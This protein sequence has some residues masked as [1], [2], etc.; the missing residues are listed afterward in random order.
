MQRTLTFEEAE[1]FKTIVNDLGFSLRKHYIAV[2][3]STMPCVGF[4]IDL[5]RHKD[6]SP[7]DTFGDSLGSPE[8][9]FALKLAEHGTSDD[10][11]SILELMSEHSQSGPV[12]RNC[13]IYFYP[14]LQWPEE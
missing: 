6:I 2:G 9:K 3:Q 5:T 11:L 14:V 4:A 1:L 8:L 12:G 7:T 10:F 13:L